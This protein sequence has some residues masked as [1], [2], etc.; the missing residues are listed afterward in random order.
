LPTLE[1][2]PT[3]TIAVD[4]VS[5]VTGA[6][7]DDGGVQTDETVA[8]TNDT[9]N[10]M[11]LLPL[12][13]VAND[14][15]YFAADA[16]Y[17]AVRLVLGTSGE[18]NWTI[19]WEYWDGAA[20]SS[21]TGVSDGTSGFT[22]AVGTHNVTFTKPADWK[23]TTIAGIAN[24]YWIRAR[25]SVFVGLVT[26]PF[27]TRA[28]TTNS[29]VNPTNAYS[30]NNSYA[31]AETTGAEQE[32]YNYHVGLMGNQV[33]DKV[34]VCLKWIAK[35][36]TVVLGDTATGTCVV[37]VHN[38]STWLNFQVTAQDYACSTGND[39]T[40]YVTDGDTSNSTTLIDVTSHINTLAKLNSVKTRLLATITVSNGATVRWSVD[41]VSILVCYHIEGGVYPKATA[42]TRRDLKTKPHHAIVKVADYLK[43]T[44]QSHT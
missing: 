41:C 32:Y 11:T 23:I 17:T 26:Q 16:P 38:G 40:F 4:A 21:L 43:Q 31:H 42:T 25:V 19:T 30:F 8:A 2:F 1:R 37:R 28:Y 33:L 7:A 10:D 22:A 29:W 13:P 12:L 24:K 6:V 3:A 36:S 9:P 20:W 44:S 14:A 34:F 39:E 5:D 15:Y 27:G 35:V 18:G